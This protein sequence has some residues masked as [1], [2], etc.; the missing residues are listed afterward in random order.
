[1]FKW[2]LRKLFV[3]SWQLSFF[4]QP[5]LINAFL[6]KKNFILYVVEL[7]NVMLYDFNVIS[8][9][10]YILFKRPWQWLM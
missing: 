4:L 5:L 3:Q 8:H 9:M 6:A 1:M 10:Q 7:Y 2:N